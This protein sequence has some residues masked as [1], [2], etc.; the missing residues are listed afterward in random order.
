MDVRIPEGSSG[1]TE[2]KPR[3]HPLAHR[4]TSEEKNLIAMCQGDGCIA[5]N[6]LLLAIFVDTILNDVLSHDENPTDL[7][8][9]KVFGMKGRELAN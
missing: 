2:T 9:I 6:N 4:G 7:N 8:I 3:G 1:F 5:W